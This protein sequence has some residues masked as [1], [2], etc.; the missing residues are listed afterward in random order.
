[1]E[2]KL[3]I[4]VVAKEVSSSQSLFCPDY[5]LLMS[6]RGK[7]YLRSTVETLLEEGALVFLP[8][9]GPGLMHLE[10]GSSVLYCAIAAGFLESMLG[11]PRYSMALLGKDEGEKVKQLLI[12]YYDLVYN[13]E[14][15][16]P[17]QLLGAGYDLLRALEPVISREVHTPGADPEAGGWSAA[18]VEHIHRNFRQPLQLEDLTREFGVSRQHLSTTIH[19]QLGV[20]FYQYLQKLR[21]QEAVGLMLTTEQTITTISEES[22]FPNLRAFN[23]VFRREYGVSPREYRAAKQAENRKLLSVP[24]PN[25]L[26]SINRLLANH[27][28]VYQ[29]SPEQISHNRT[30]L[31]RNGAVFSPVW[32][33]ILN[34]E[35]ASECLQYDVR[36]ALK[37]ITGEIPFRYVRMSN[38]LGKELTA[39]I[40][41]LKTHRFT[42]LFEVIEFLRELGLTPMLAL[43]NSDK[44][45][46]GA[47]M[48]DESYTVGMQD[49]LE[50]LHNMLDA[51]V[52]H[53]G[54]RWVSTWRF[55]FY[56]PERLYGQTD[57]EVFFDLFEASYRLIR[58]HL[59]QAEIGGPAMAMDGAH[60]SRW[61]QW[62]EAVRQRGIQPD[63]VSTELWAD[64][65]VRTDG[66]PGQ[67]LEWRESKAVERLDAADTALVGQ[68]IASLRGLMAEFG[69]DAKLYV[70]ALG[71]TKHQAAAAQIGGHCSAYL[72]RSLLELQGLVDGVGCW[73]A[74]NHEAEYPDIYSVYSTGCGLMSRYALKNPSWYA[75]SFLTKLPKKLLLRDNHCIVTTDGLEHY[76]VLLHNCKNYSSYFCKNYLLPQGETFTEE[77][78]YTDNSARKYNVT[79]SGIAPGAYLV[80]QYLIGD[81]HGC[82]A[83]V[84]REMGQFRKL[85][86]TE[87]AY[88][89]GQSMPFQ[90]NYR[91]TAERDLNF[92]VTLQPNET[93]LMMIEPEETPG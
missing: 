6:L 30:V 61:R 31:V 42:K 45:T 33:D 32:Q 12:E 47:V 16:S 24:E 68:K 52:L 26:E 28:M 77:R 56:M 15:V 81:H 66:F 35:D 21:L 76:S 60:L 25:V 13:R 27:R 1:M 86:R 83:Q 71:I 5:L 63:F 91:V 23:T 14:S 89:A 82:I 3:P 39:Y 36:Q 10:G 78:M 73:K 54:K 58:E 59:P 55:E 40:P 29:R 22:G 65:T 18:V 50:M 34:I 90:H 19:R 80:R 38:A 70:S 43:G 4:S 92:S 62:L 8:P 37:E 74:V 57:P 53:W 49:W 79:L 64:H 48:L 41:A 88:V 75:Y 87:V 20:S 2:N 67:Y 69:L 17:L 9:G 44:V 93:M 51:A 7:V 72:I 46:L 85:S 11:G 84:L